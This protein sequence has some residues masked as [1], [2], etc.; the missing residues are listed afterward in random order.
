MEP[1]GVALEWPTR[2]LPKPRRSA[3]G[4]HAQPGA[5]LAGWPRRAPEPQRDMTTCDEG[6]WIRGFARRKKRAASAAS[7]GARLDGRIKRPKRTKAAKAVPL[8][9]DV[10]SA[11][12]EAASVSGAR[13]APAHDARGS[14]APRARS[15]RVHA[16]RALPSQGDVSAPSAAGAARAVA[17]L[18]PLPSSG[19]L[20]GMTC[21]QLREL[22]RA[23]GVPVTG[24]KRELVRALLVRAREALRAAPITAAGGPGVSGAPS[25]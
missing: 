3:F 9:A 14:A 23:H 25:Q 16:R 5:Q 4:A 12:S 15:A 1:D 20:H 11:L 2:K 24:A 18:P 10:P 21:P 22:A 17:P 19:S 8:P 7:A 13:S 6:A